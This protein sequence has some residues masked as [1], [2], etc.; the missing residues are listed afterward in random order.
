MKYYEK[1]LS[2]ACFNLED[3]CLLTGN[4]NT[5]NSLMQSYLKK[6]Y[7]QSVKRNLYVAINLADN[8]PVAN[9]YL[10]GSHI[11][12]SAYISHHSALAYYGYTNQVVNE[13]YVSSGTVFRSFEFEGL[14]YKFLKSRIEEGIVKGIDGVKVTDIERTVI[15]SINDFEKVAGLEE[16]LRSFSLIPLLDEQKLLKYLKSYNKQVLFQK[17][18]YILEHFKRELNLSDGFFVSCKA[19]IKKSVQ[20]LSKSFDREQIK[21]N[22]QWQLLVPN[23]LLLLISKGRLEDADI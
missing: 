9:R 7:V 21:Y 10:L 19:G 5:A 16:L 12:D 4:M 20:Y 22:S 2:M 17:T 1:L 23:D 14:V 15:D 3:V 6:G 13:V 8:S 11:T 18:G